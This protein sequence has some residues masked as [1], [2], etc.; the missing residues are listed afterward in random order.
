MAKRLERY[1]RRVK[2]SVW[3]GDRTS[4]ISAL[5]DTAE[6]AES[7]RRLWAQISKQLVV[8]ADSLETLAGL[9]RGEPFQGWVD[10]D[11][12]GELFEDT[13]I[14]DQFVEKIE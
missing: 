14:A 4:L 3:C 8:A 6:A 13:E 1:S 5:A 12:L 10:D 9:L 2:D 11:I 7:A